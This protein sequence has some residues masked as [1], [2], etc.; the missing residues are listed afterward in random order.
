M[1]A[2]PC[3]ACG[4]PARLCVMTPDAIRC[5]ACGFHGA[6]PAEAAA[7]LAEAARVLKATDVRARQLSAKFA[8]SLARA[9]WY[10]L[11]FLLLSALVLVPTGLFVAFCV[12]AWAITEAEM[13][14][15]FLVPVAPYLVM[16]G[17][18]WKETRGIIVP[19]VCLAPLRRLGLVSSRTRE[20][21]RR[22]PFP[23]LS[24]GEDA[25]ARP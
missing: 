23:A 20:A 22:L 18:T 14:R 16:L 4:K 11:R 21:V 24:A 7:R 1:I 15:L 9:G 19:G 3:P 5:G 10:Q 2:A 6:V 17:V 25:V 8:E 12:F 13:A